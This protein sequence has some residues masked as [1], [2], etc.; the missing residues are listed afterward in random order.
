MVLELTP[1]SQQSDG[2]LRIAFVPAA[3]NNLSVAILT[4]GTTKDL[5]YSFTPDGFNRQY[6]ESNV[7]DPRLA[8]V[9]ILN[10]PG[11]FTETLDVKYVMTDGSATD[12]AYTALGGGGLGQVAALL[13]LRYA[14][15][16]ATIWT[17]GQK[18]DS[19]TILS[20]K[21]RRDPIAANGLFT[22][23]QSLYLTAPTVSQTPLVA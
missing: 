23:T 15:A 14:I 4:G 2:F 10:R 1:P 7:P 17:I 6:T 12:I 13:T 5:T 22:V 11:T 19:L 20:G 9:Q 21:P 8:N 3:S 18:V 16:N